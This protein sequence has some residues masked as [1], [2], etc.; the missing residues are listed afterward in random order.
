MIANVS[1]SDVLDDAEEPDI[2]D[3]H[4]DDDF[5]ITSDNIAN[6]FPKGVLKSD[7]T[8]SSLTFRGYFENLGVLN[9]N[10]DNVTFNG[11]NCVFFNTVFDVS[12]NNITLSDM[13]FILNE[14]FEEVEGSCI[15][16]KGNNVVLN[17]IHINY[18][19]SSDTDAYAVYSYG[20]SKEPVDNLTIVNS[21]IDFVGENYVE[22]VYNYAVRL[23][24]SPN[25]LIENNTI[26]TKLIL[27]PVNFNN[28]YVES[29]SDY[30]LS[31]GASNSDNLRFISNNV[32]S[33]AIGRLFGFPTLDCFFVWGCDNSYV[34]NNSFVL[35]DFFTYP[36]VDNYLY[37]L[38]IY[39]LDNLTVA[40]NNISVM[41]TGG[42]LSAGAA[43]PIQLTGPL[44]NVTIVYNYL[45]SI[46]NGPNIGIYSN[47]VGG[48]TA[49]FIAYN[50]VNI[51]GLASEDEWGLVAGFELQDSKD[52]VISNDIEVHS[53]GEVNESTNIYGISYSQSVPDEHSF[54]I[55]N[56]TVLSDG[57]YS[58]Y[59]L[60][61]VN[62]TIIHNTLLSNQE[63]I[64]NSYNGYKRGNGAHEWELYYNNRVLNAFDYFAQIANDID[65][66]YVFNYT[67][68]ENDEYLSNIIDARGID[69]R[70]IFIIPF[71]NPLITDGS[72]RHHTGGGAASNY[73]DGFDQG[74]NAMG[75]NTHG[76]NS[77]GSNYSANSS[78][79]NSSSDL[80]FSGESGAD[81]HGGN[82]TYDSEEVKFRMFLTVTTVIC[83]IIHIL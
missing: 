37:G 58:V 6:Y 38:D 3:L 26:N 66:G 76:G 13:T 60:S 17:N 57:F 50:K 18:T 64:N 59:L 44:N 42:K 39:S 41:T 73:D 81:N 15:L 72:I 20:T 77:S 16:I 69:G 46:S 10:R 27:K 54:D 1:A 12:A 70:N 82:K 51:T 5:N 7:Y 49:L 43:Y 65:S 56:N 55:I 31:V 78:S 22:N 80:P 68:A 21:V 40:Y 28:I 11:N 4:V 32:T 74:G 23:D 79:G 47:N 75:N 53:V 29:D 8:N 9:V 83:R 67:P 30:S 48:N 45:Y 25:A 14:S 63:N 61:A 19:A 24:Y 71:F 52:M 62:S 33:D 35:T 36:G 2:P 34:L